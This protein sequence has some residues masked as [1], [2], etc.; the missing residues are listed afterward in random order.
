MWVFTDCV[1]VSSHVCFRMKWT[2][3]WTYGLYS[4]RQSM[5]GMKIRNS[6]VVCS[7]LWISPLGNIWSGKG[8]RRTMKSHMQTSNMA[9]TSMFYLFITSVTLCC[10]SCDPKWD[11]T[12]PAWTL[13]YQNTDIY[14]LSVLNY[15]TVSHWVLDH[16]GLKMSCTMWL[17]CNRLE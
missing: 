11:V 17:T 16:D 8:I 1:T 13:C 6:F 5:S 9:G 15:C 14:S 4:K 2:S 12:G 10:C 7:S 3:V